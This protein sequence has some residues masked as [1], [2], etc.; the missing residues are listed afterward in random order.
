MKSRASV[1]ALILSA[2]MKLK[3]VALGVAK[4]N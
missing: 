3:K 2:G 4:F 1:S